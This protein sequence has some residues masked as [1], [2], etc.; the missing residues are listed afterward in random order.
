MGN[1]HKVVKY[2]PANMLISNFLYHIMENV[3]NKF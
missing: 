3:F 2:I 1:D